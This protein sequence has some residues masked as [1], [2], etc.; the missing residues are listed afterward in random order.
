MSRRQY[1]AV[2]CLIVAVAAVA[3][4]VLGL[5]RDK[6]P[7]VGS[8]ASTT[9]ISTTAAAGPIHVEAGFETLIDHQWVRMP[10]PER[11]PMASEPRLVFLADGTVD[12]YDGCDTWTDRIRIVSGVIG[13]RIPRALSL[14]AS[15]QQEQLEGG[16]YTVVDDGGVR[17][18]ELHSATGELLSRY[19]AVDTMPAIGS[20]ELVGTWQAA[21]GERLT[22]DST[23]DA[24]LGP[25][26]PAAQWALA[27][28][29]LRITGFAARD[30]A[31]ACAGGTISG[32]ARQLLEMLLTQNAAIEAHLDGGRLLMSLGTG[33]DVWLEPVDP[34]EPALDLRRGTTYGFAPMTDVSS[35]F[36]VSNVS[37]TAGEP[38]FDSGWYVTPHST[39]VHESDCFGGVQMRAVQWGDLALG[40]LR[41]PSMA[42]GQDRLWISTVGDATTFDEYMRLEEPLPAASGSRTVSIDGLGVGS[43]I[44]DIQSAGF[45][46]SNIRGADSQRVADPTA[47]TSATLDSLNIV[48]IELGNGKVTAIVVQNPGFC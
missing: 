32:T 39:L 11:F 33:H 45:T 19:V 40:F 17:R 14:C 22:V 15:A 37:R 30:E 2:G 44:S 21:T 23:G 36:I 4:V 25:C 9:S 34:Q 12:G 10:T 20:A 1:A 35:D 26:D 13:F 31:T 47:A 8:R 46:L 41:L 27:G 38:T 3:V 48:S 29:V 16:V 42:A 5:N 6:Q 28:T 7:S 24:S 18:L 43:T